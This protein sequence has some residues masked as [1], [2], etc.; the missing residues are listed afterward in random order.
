MPKSPEKL[1]EFN[2]EEPKNDEE[3]FDWNKRIKFAEE[4]LKQIKELEEKGNVLEAK[5]GH[6]NLVADLIKAQNIRS[7]DNIDVY[8]KEEGEED[9]DTGEFVELREDELVV[10]DPRDDVDV[11]IPVKDIT[12]V[13]CAFPKSVKDIIDKHLP[14]RPEDI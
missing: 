14:K 5:R 10:R 6:Y 2:G 1:E 9:S 13:Y 12:D 7:G 3:V 8:F 11:G 4:R